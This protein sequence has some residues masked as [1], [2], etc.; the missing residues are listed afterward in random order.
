MNYSET[1]FTQLVRQA[2]EYGAANRNDISQ[3]VF[4]ATLAVPTNLAYFIKGHGGQLGTHQV[5]PE[6]R[7]IAAYFEKLG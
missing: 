3:D 1:Q 6:F 4:N 7:N 2:I 5:H